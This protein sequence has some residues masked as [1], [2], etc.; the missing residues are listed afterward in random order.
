MTNIK[1]DSAHQKE[2]IKRYLELINSEYQEIKEYV[3][4]EIFSFEQLDKCQLGYSFDPDGNSL[5]TEGEGYHIPGVDNCLGTIE[6]V[7]SIERI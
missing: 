6:K 4:L 5:V 1:F 3:D 2:K 7:I